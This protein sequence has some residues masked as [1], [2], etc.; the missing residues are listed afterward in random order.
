[1]FYFILCFDFRV[2]LFFTHLEWHMIFNAK[3]KNKTFFLYTLSNDI[4]T[5]NIWVKRFS[6]TL[7]ANSIAIKNDFSTSIVL[8]F[9]F[10]DYIIK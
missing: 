3:S 7:V 9:Y 6:C 1:M 2:K 10:V 4:K 8:V 5:Q